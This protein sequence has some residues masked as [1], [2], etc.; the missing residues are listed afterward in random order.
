MQQ[1]SVQPRRVGGRTAVKLSRQNLTARVARD[2]RNVHPSAFL[3]ELVK[4]DA[5]LISNEFAGN[6]QKRLEGWRFKVHG[7]S[8][9]LLPR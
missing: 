5:Q 9:E 2:K 1:G 8:R 7:I 4:A 3:D 6:L